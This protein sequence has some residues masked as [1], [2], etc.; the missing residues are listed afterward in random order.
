MSERGLLELRSVQALR[1]AADDLGVPAEDLA[2][3]L[4]GG[5]IA[6]LLRL[7]NAAAPHVEA[8]GLRHRIENLLS[9][10]TDGRMPMF[11]KPETDLDFAMDTLRQRRRKREL[12]SAD[13]SASESADEPA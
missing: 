8:A 6:R 13:D 3:R 2:T 4:Q 9:A 10:V 1:S 5:E 12:D 7:L 11:E